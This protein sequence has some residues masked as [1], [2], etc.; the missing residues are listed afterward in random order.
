MLGLGNR[1]KKNKK[2]V[3]ACID[4]GSST[5]TCSIAH[6]GSDDQINLLGIG[7]QA[8]SG[9]HSGTV[10]DMVAAEE[11]IVNAVHQA[12]LQAGFTIKEA[13][14]S[15]NGVNFS[16]HCYRGEVPITGH[17]VDDSDV[18]RVFQEACTAAMV[19]PGW[20]TI[21]VLPLAYSID[22]TKGIRD[23][24]GMYGDQLKV[25]VHV[26]SG[27]SAPI[28]T[29]QT[30]V[31][32]CHL[33]IAGLVNAP[34][35]SG[36]STLVE[37]EQDMGVTLIDMGAG[38][39]SF[40]IFHKGQMVYTGCIPLGGQHVTSDIARGLS[41]P[42]NHAERLKTMYGTALV[43]SGEAREIMMVPQVG[44][45]R[46]DGVNQMS[47]MA[48]V[49]IIKPRLEEIF[50]MVKTQLQDA[51]MDVCAG[52]R[53]VLTGGA[54]QIA[55]LRELASLILDKNVRLGRPHTLGNDELVSD[56]GFAV[57][58]GLLESVQLGC[59]EKP[60]VTTE[61]GSTSKIS[62]IGGALKGIW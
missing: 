56:P 28:Q 24:R 9:I 7:R 25:I 31:G 43:S 39:T 30:C 51:R 13:Y 11:S 52:K 61:R 29:L 1:S 53:V 40:S 32:R 60:I 26:V 3:I 55:G 58:A 18:K 57:C 46:G 36:L 14:I 21:H 16:S 20:Q 22:Q 34:Y 62:K 48:L 23:P 37:D 27:K 19:E 47:R 33:D 4:A 49:S 42:M 54:S 15:V 35:A 8:A 45:G 6:L 38:T 5:V 44:E 10:V 12:E 41:T 50:E 59:M 17:S 2:G